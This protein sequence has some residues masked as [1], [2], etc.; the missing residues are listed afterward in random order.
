M[1]AEA[2]NI[3]VPVRI[4]IGAYFQQTAIDQLIQRAETTT[5]R[6]AQD[7]RNHSR[8]E[9]AA[10]NQTRHAKDTANRIVQI[11]VTQPETRADGQVIDLEMS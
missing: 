11:E 9:I 1:K 4:G 10:R 7:R 3:A 5:L 2:V 6:Y 8:A